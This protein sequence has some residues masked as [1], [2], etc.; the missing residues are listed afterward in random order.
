MKLQQLPLG[1][2]FEYEGAVYV[3]PGSMTASSE[4]GGQSAISIHKSLSL[5]R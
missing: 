4:L 5:P 3:N 1:G 2:R